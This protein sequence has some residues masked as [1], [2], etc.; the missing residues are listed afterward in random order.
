M[1]GFGRVPTC[2]LIN[3]KTPSFT[4]GGQIEARP[5]TL[6]GS[7]VANL[8]RVMIIGNLG[9][10]PEMRFTPSGSAVT[11]FRIA[12]NWRFITSDGERM[13]ETEWFTVLAWDRL[14]EGCNDR[15]SKGSR[16]YVEGRFRRRS[17]QG[18]DGQPRSRSE[19]VA[20]RVLFLDR[21]NAGT[22]SQHDAWE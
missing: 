16:A 15:L 14:A 5:S 18:S 9:T 3:A 22:S 4:P 1:M 7:E 21:S 13:E 19:I 11:T 12:T 8:N 20:R 10:D 2:A 6:Q 17:W